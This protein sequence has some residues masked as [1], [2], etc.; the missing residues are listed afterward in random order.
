MT[1]RLYTLIA[2]YDIVSGVGSILS[3]VTLI[4]LMYDQLSAVAYVLP[5]AYSM[6]GL[7]TFVPVLSTVSL[8]VV[9]TIN[10]L[11]PFYTVNRRALYCVIV[12]Y[13]VAWL[14]L[15]VYECFSVYMVWPRIETRVYYL[16]ISRMVGGE[17]IFYLDE[18]WKFLSNATQTSVPLFLCVGVPFVLPSVICLVCAVTQVVALHRGTM[19]SKGRVT[20]RR[21]TIT[22][23]MLTAAFTVCNSAGFLVVFSV[24]HLSPDLAKIKRWELYM[25]FISGTMLPVINSL[26]NPLILISRGERLR[27]Y[28]AN[29]YSR[30]SDGNHGNNSLT[31]NSV[32]QDKLREGVRDCA[33]P[34]GSDS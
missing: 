11:L 25:T 3:A 27:Q 34:R 18:H 16:F 32:L 14:P 33:R 21:I 5:I 13:Q 9:R 4:L 17:V 15:L 24:L 2:A 12:A 19:S 26:L 1:H 20:N 31:M 30:P 7:A 22:V 28:F 6:T 10:I 8:A 23:V 29:I